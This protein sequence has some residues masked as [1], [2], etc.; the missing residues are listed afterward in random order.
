MME[1]GEDLNSDSFWRTFEQYSQEKRSTFEPLLLD[2][3]EHDFDKIGEL[4]KPNPY[5]KKIIETLKDKGY[6]LFL[7]TMPLFPS[8]A[9][10]VRLRWAGIED[11]SVFDRITT[12]DNSHAVKPYLEYFQENINLADGSIEEILMVG[13]NTREDLACCKLG[14]DAFLVTDWL[15]DPD[16]FDYSQMKHGSLE[17]FYAFVQNLPELH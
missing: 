15:L 1:A 13:N 9:V 11:P 2:F 6:Q 10:E 7:T 8:I 17:D 5:A 4:I 14:V 12:Y 3:Y 16:G